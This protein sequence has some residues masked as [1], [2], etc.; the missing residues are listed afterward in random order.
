M[1]RLVFKKKE[2]LRKFLE[3]ADIA[4]WPGIP[5]IT[6]QE[7]IYANNIVLLPKDS[8]SSN[9]I[10]SEYLFFSKDLNQV[11]NNIIKIF[12][13]TNLISR[14]RNKNKKILNNLEWLN[15]N[16]DLEKY[17]IGH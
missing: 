2:R 9:L 4:I 17:Y 5:S 8:A 12:S 14:I 13:N 7:A 15:I 1:L 3:L 16:K 10:T 6:I 11:A